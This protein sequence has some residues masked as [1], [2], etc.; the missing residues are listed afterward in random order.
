MSFL[1]DTNVLLR[2]IEPLHPQHLIAVE[3]VSTLL[4]ESGLVYFSHQ[5]IA[6]FWCV[7]TRPRHKNGLGLSVDATLKEVRQIERLL[8]LLP[9]TPAIYATWKQLVVEHRVSGVKVHDARLVATM[10]THGVTE[11]LTFNVDD[12]VRYSE[13]QVRHPDSVAT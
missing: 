3:A 13:I 10:K 5:N 8:T 2:S 6:E 11:L 1:V 12:F 7:A 9:D 4:S